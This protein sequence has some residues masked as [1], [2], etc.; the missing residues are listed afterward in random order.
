MKR[1][2]SCLAALVLLL[3]SAVSFAECEHRVRP[4]EWL[5]QGYVDPQPGIPGYSGDFCCP[6]CGAVMRKGE[7][8]GA[9]PVDYDKEKKE[10]EQEDPVPVPVNIGSEAPEAPS[11]PVSFPTSQKPEIETER[12]HFSEQYPFRRV[13][14]NPEPGIVAPAAG[15]LIWSTDMEQDNESTFIPPNVIPAKGIE[16]LMVN[17]TISGL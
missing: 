9:L 5:L 11:A 2:I 3:L 14:M 7:V 1:I 4:S 17:G 13:Q 15:E 12:E 16:D 6:V 8:I 10:A